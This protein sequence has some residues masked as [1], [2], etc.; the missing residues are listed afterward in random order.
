M[1]PRA[2]VGHK[3][4]LA[5]PDDPSHVPLVQAVWSSLAFDY[6]ARQKLSGTSM[7][8]FVVAQ[9]ACPAP[10]VFEV[11]QPWSGD[12]LLREWV[13]PRV[14]ELSYTSWRIR[15]YAQDLGDDG[16]PFRWLPER[17]ELLR[18]ELDAAMC[19]VYGLTRPEVE[20]VLESFFVVRKYEERDHGEF[21]TKRLVLERYDAMAAAAR[22]DQPYQTVLDP[23]PGHG[24]RHG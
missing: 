17:R 18:A 19:H 2:A 6:V 15:P 20:H 3:F 22:A 16:P 8:Y 12:L 24:P 7:S 5:F 4:P 13:L 23:P 21:R 11:P 14:L 9:L 1:L 10:E